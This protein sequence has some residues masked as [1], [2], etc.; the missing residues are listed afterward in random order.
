MEQSIQKQQINIGRDWNQAPN[1]S[2]KTTT[3]NKGGKNNLIWWI[4]GIVGT[5]IATVIG[6]ALL[7]SLNIK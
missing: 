7:K 1:G 4:L 2:I 3:H 5:I 6:K